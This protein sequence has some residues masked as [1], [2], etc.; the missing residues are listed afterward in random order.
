MIANRCN[1]LDSLMT[2]KNPVYMTHVYYGDPSPEF[3]LQLIHTLAEN[4]ADIIEFGIPFSDPTSDGPA[5]Q[6]A[7]QR[8]IEHGM[9]PSCAMAGISRLR[10]EGIE[11][12][13]VVTSYYNILHNM[14]IERFIHRI[15]EA[16]AD[17]VL[18]PDLPVEEASELEES[19]RRE[20]IR[21]LFM[22]S[23]N[24]PQSRLK[25]ILSHAKG[26]LYLTSVMGVTGVREMLKLDI[27]GVISRV[28][29]I[30]P[31]PILVGFGISKAEHAREAVLCG[32]S[33]VVTG[34]AIC[35]IYES[36]IGSPQ[37]SL[38]AIAQFVREIRNG[39]DS[40]AG[41]GMGRE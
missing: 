27:Q 39:C 29:E 1:R 13:V 4:G 20:N 6:R 14:G 32:A 7:C 5:F 22:I 26:F 36:V 24:T 2:H 10:D 37:D 18:V 21:V 9:T 3:S 41:G 19:G 11:N 33:G 30:S 38:D 31:I 35:E 25:V 12:P 28:R 15:A 40:A 23:P 17:A 34:S 8:A 16:G